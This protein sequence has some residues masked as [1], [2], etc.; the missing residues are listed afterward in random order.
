MKKLIFLAAILTLMASTVFAGGIKT[1]Y[2]NALILAY[3][4]ANS[5]YEDD[6]I[7]SEIYNEQ[8]WATNKTKKTI[9]IDLAQCFA[10]HNGAAKPLFDPSKNKQGDDKKASKKGVSTKDDEFITIAPSIGTKQNE[11]FICNMS[12]YIYGNYST[13]ESP[14]DDF[15]D[16]DKRLLSI[17]EELVSE[18]LNVDP[19]G[20]EYK[21]TTVRHLTEDESINNIGASVA[22]AFNKNTENWTNISLSTWVSDVIFAP[23]YVEMPQDLKKKDKKGFGIKET[24]PAVIHVRANSP[25]EFDEDKSP[26]IVCDWQGN[27]KK[28][29]FSL[30]HTWILKKQNTSVWKVL[31]G[32]VTFGAT[33]YIPLSETAYKKIIHF[34]GADNN[35]GKLSYASEIMKTGQTD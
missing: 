15:T 19:K 34:D 21:G 11:T 20:K 29:T 23:Y 17:V 6:N 10:F 33:W 32:F 3:S 8:L 24:A 35:W 30:S 26:I 25:F 31:G 2:R 28:G 22:Y 27:Y 9:F 7:K 16:Y 4:Q 18:S 13:S 14:S 1:D 12:T 5:V